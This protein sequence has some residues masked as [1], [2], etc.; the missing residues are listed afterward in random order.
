MNRSK[1]GAEALAHTLKQAATEVGVQASVTLDHPILEGALS[2]ADLCCVIGGDGSLLGVAP[3][4][5]RSQVPVMGINLGKLGF[6]A[7]SSAKQ[8]EKKLL[9]IL[10]GRNQRSER[11]MLR[12]VTCDGA[13]E[14]GLN[15]VVFKSAEGNRLIELDVFADDRLV[16]QYYSDG[17]VFSTPTGSTAYNLSAGG[18][19]IDSEAEIIAMTPVCPHTLSNR[20][21]VFGADTKLSVAVRDN[22]VPP[23]VTIDGRIIKNCQDL[24]P[25]EVSLCREKLTLI[26]SLDYVPFDVVRNKLGWDH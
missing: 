9:E 21:V 8:G 13:E 17:L 26:H 22:G 24:F 5:F 15:D 1:K 7:T 25:I 12:C 20:S 4:A 14:L 10:Q 23:Q 16:T 2:D 19:L 3:E 18:P 11:C 6:M